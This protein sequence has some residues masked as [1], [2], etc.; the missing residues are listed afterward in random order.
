MDLLDASK[1][2]PDGNRYV[3]VFTDAASGFLMAVPVKNKSAKEAVRA[4]ELLDELVPLPARARHRQRHE[5]REGQPAQPARIRRRAPQDVDAV[6]SP[7][8][9]QG[10]EGGAGGPKLSR[11]T[12]ST[13]TAR[14]TRS[15]RTW[16]RHTTH[17]STPRPSSR[18]TSSCSG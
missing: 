16:C 11:Q 5:L 13:T 18:R 4:F 6:Q 8:Q 15:C 7:R 17:R 1:T 12:A 14:G 9:R 2:T 3:I 10:R